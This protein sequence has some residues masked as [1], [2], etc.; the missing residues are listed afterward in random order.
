MRLANKLTEIKDDLG[1]RIKYN[2]NVEGNKES[3]QIWDPPREGYPDGELKKNLDFAYDEYNR[4]KRITTPDEPRF[5]GHP[6]IFLSRGKTKIFIFCKNSKLKS[7][8]DFG[9]TPSL[10]IPLWIRV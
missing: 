9:N 7:R 6:I 4:L 5:R 3:E 10:R 1:N 2:Y 8:P